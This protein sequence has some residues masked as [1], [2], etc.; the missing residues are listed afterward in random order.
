M[1]EQLN[2]NNQPEKE[3][4]QAQKVEEKKQQVAKWSPM[5]KLVYSAKTSFE[6]VETDLNF[7]REANFALQVLESNSF[8]Q[9]LEQQ[10]I[11]NSVKNISLIGLTLNPAM[12]YAYLV[13]RNGKCTLDISYIGMIKLLTDAGTVKNIS[14]DV[15][16]QSEVDNGRFDYRKGSDPY[17]KHKP[18]VFASEKNKGAMVGA[19]A[20]AYFRDGGCQFEL[21]GKEEM[22]KIKNFSESYK[23]EKTRKY[24][25][26][27]NWEPE[28]W[29]KT[30]LRRLYK[31]LP[32]T[33]MSDKLIAAL[34][35]EHENEQ[36]DLPTEQRY[37]KFFD[38]VEAEVVE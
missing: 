35:N 27:E 13:P 15:V 28:M 24:S 36:N 17:L 14:A 38:D 23:N 3:K 16:Y 29:K 5:Q 9:K 10:S 30:V 6:S 34:G 31:M 1:S 2:L 11:I 21:M 37:E 26:W 19:Y 33:Q 32:K 22:D 4:E 7:N 12:K 8:L 18:D 25:P 20:I